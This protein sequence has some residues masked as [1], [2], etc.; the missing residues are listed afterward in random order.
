[1]N[2]VA[3]RIGATV[4]AIF[5]CAIA[6]TALLNVHKFSALFTEVVEDRLAFAV[7]DIR[8]SVEAGLNLGVPLGALTRTQDILEEN[9]RQDKAILSIEVFD[10]G[11]QVLFGTDRGFIGDLVAERWLNIWRRTP[12]GTW[13]LSDP[14]SLVVGTALVT[15]VG[16]AAGGIVLRYSRA[17][18]AEP[19]ATAQVSLVR[20]GAL[21]TAAT[22]GLVFVGVWLLLRPTLISFLRMERTAAA[23]C[24]DSQVTFAPGDGLPMEA[25]FAAFLGTA[26]EAMKDMQAATAEIHRLD[27]GDDGDFGP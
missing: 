25:T 19:I 21:L 12:T 22:A 16:E 3:V 26:A 4:V 9:L 18:L 11:G 1:M 6:L 5:V 20:L 13:T 14:E 23:A 7:E 27:E 10:Q 17:A 2:S 24:D 8:V 15:S